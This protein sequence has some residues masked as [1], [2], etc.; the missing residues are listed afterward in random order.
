MKKIITLTLLAGFLLEPLAAQN[1][2][3]YPFLASQKYGKCF[4]AHKYPTGDLSATTVARKYEC[5]AQ[6]NNSLG[7]LILKCQLPEGPSTFVYAQSM[8]SCQ[9]ALSALQELRR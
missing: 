2:S 6:V 4:N 8:L 1:L 3:S 7:G 5:S 9:R